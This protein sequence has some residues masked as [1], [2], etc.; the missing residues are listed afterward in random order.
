VFDPSM[1][2][3]FAAPSR[4][5][6]VEA[7]AEARDLGHHFIDSQHL[8]LGLL[9]PD[10]DT[11]SPV[12]ALLL[13][14]GLDLDTVRALVADAEPRRI[15]APIIGTIPFTPGCKSVL[16]LSFR[17]SLQHSSGE[18]QPEH[19]LLGM[20]RDR[21]SQACK[22][23]D[24]VGITADGVRAWMASPTTGQFQRQHQARLAWMPFGGQSTSGAR[25]VLSEARKAAGSNDLVGSQHILLGL[26]AEGKG[27]GAKVLERLGVTKEAIDGAI[28]ELGVDGTS[29]G[30]PP[31]RVTKVRNGGELR[32]DD[33]DLA[34]RLSGM[35]AVA[36][37]DL[38]RKALL[39]DTRREGAPP[40]A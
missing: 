40:E 34:E 5:V 37:G 26:V 1:F 14:A 27:L 31:L 30:P 35:D 24:S 33:P 28:S 17:E 16:E 10:R 25:H 3:R 8:I 19:L 18:I 13:S 29:D 36:A 22:L 21:R 38:I 23:L 7:E 2:E 20:L 4:R 32:I 6:L 12:R 39:G 15:S 11:N 9:V